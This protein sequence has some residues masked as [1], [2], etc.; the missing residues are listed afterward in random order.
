LWHRLK[1]C[2]TTEPA[3]NPTG[4]NLKAA[5]KYVPDLKNLQWFETRGP[6]N[7]LLRFGMCFKI[8]L[9]T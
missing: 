8:G 1:N 2:S 6:Q 5:G 4:T 3:L 7:S 9:D